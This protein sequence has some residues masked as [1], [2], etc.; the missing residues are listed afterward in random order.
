MR[1]RLLWLGVICWV[2][3]LAGGFTIW[4]ES[5]RV[6][7]PDGTATAAETAPGS[8]VLTVYVH[9][10]C[11]CTRTGLGELAELTTEAPAP[12]RVGLVFVRPPG[13]VT[14]WERGRT[15][16]AAAALPWAA[17]R[18]DEGGTEAR[19]AGA[20]GSGHATLTAP[21]GR[22]VFRGGINRGRGWA[23]RG[24][25][26][27]AVVAWVTGTPGAAATAPV[28]GCRLFDSTTDPNAGGG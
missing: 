25:G 11:P 17:V 3:A 26:R 9:P 12:L 28:F 4:H 21:D 5:E 2:A 16:A 18:T 23:T 20:V 1:D 19:A 22:V 24:P 13:V 27:A 15:W 10:H 8:W 14:G 7:A 6:P